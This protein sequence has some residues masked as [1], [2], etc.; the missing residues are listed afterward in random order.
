MTGSEVRSSFSA[1]SSLSEPIEELP[2][3]TAG[4]SNKARERD[5][6]KISLGTERTI[7]VRLMPVLQQEPRREFLFNLSKP[8]VLRNLLIGMAG[9]RSARTPWS[10]GPAL[11]VK[12]PLGKVFSK[13]DLISSERKLSWQAGWD[14]IIMN[15]VCRHKGVVDFR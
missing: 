9:Q 8:G 1:S 5:V 13:L 15:S 14:D 2:A 4:Q 6:R 11:A 10:L 7:M 3:L 12:Q